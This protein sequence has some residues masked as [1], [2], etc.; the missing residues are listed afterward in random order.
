MGIPVLHCVLGE[1]AD[2]V[3]SS[4][5]GLVVEPE[6]PVALCESIIRIDGD[7]DLYRTYKANCAA[8]AAKYDRANLASTMLQHVIDTVK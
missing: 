1:S 8:A 2:I 6:D 4:Q 5:I 7:D 3:E